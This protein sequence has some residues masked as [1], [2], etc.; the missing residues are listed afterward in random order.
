LKTDSRP[1]DHWRTWLLAASA[2]VALFGLLLVLSPAAARLG[3]SV[4]IYGS[5]G[6]IDA[7]GR[8]QVGYIS[9]VHAVL[10]GV[11]VGWGFALFY[12]VKTFF[13]KNPG[14]T[15]N[16][17]A[18]SLVAWFVPDTAY[19]LVSGYWPNALLNGGFAVVFFIPLWA[20]RGA[21]QSVI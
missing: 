14:G 5:T 21:R 20:T 1:V 2:G 17:V 6:T 8:E 12:A 4:M 11:M 16:L 10:G 15:W 9:L 13:V 19:S 18:G 7:F 3:F